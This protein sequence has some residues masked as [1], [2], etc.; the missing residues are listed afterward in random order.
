MTAPGAC[1]H[2]RTAQM[3]EECVHAA[4]LADPLRA[5]ATR[6]ELYPYGHG[7]MVSAGFLHADSEAAQAAAPA[8]PKKAAPRKRGAP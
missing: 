7:G 4:A 3:C 5:A 6:A 8:A 2:G 1:P